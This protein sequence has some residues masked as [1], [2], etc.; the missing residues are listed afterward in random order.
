MSPPHLP[1]KHR[2]VE[3]AQG[4]VDSKLDGHV[5]DVLEQRGERSR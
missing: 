3:G 5:R 1:V 4:L 2:L